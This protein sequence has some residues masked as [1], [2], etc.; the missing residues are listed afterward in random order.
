MKP[1]HTTQLEL[2]VH[3]QLRNCSEIFLALADPIRQDIIMILTK[4]EKLNVSQILEHSSMSRSAISHHLKI[5]RQANLV[6]ANKKGTEIFYSLHIEDAVP[7]LKAFLN[8][9][10]KIMASKTSKNE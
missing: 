1:S 7:Q 2:K 6:N 4:H 3:Q 9:T 10:E 8:T 5:L